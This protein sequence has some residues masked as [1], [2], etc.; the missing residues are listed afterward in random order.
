[1]H[2]DRIK[3]ETNLFD[4][5]DILRSSIKFIILSFLFIL[6][7]GFIFF[8]F[9]D[10]YF[11]G[12]LEI[13][14]VGDREIS[15]FYSFNM[16]I[17]AAF[18]ELEGGSTVSNILISPEKLFTYFKKELNE[19]NII[20]DVTNEQL[21]KIYNNDY[22]ESL[23]NEISN[24]FNLIKKD[25]KD[26]IYFENQFRDLSIIVLEESIIRINK[27]IYDNLHYEIDKLVKSI[28]TRNNIELSFLNNELLL[29]EQSFVSYNN[30]RITHLIEQSKI[31]R[32]L[33]IANNKTID[34]IRM[35]DTLISPEINVNVDMFLHDYFRG[36]LAL[37][38]EIELLQKRADSNIILYDEKYNNLVLEVQ[39][40][41]T[42]RKS[43]LLKS[44]L[45]S[46]PSIDEF[47]AITYGKVIVSS[48]KSLLKTA[49][50]FIIMGLIL[51]SI[52]IIM[53]EL[54]RRYSS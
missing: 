26:Y 20:K 44:G 48:S 12:N 17:G 3:T 30:M 29:A 6:L 37:E 53:T 14:K 47:N 35:S 40:I 15:D 43:Q 22:D 41:E 39:R 5:F 24:S 11:K 38:K 10:E 34:E 32:E 49:L 31:A 2:E 50:F 16:S 46:L 1:M 52:Y 9:S 33:G 27:K 21:K 25:N 18:G 8:Q 19:K 13:K 28:E 42:D 23:I 45:G 7:I 4:L 54:Y 51:P 36:Y